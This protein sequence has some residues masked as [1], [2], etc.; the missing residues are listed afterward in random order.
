MP[1][2]LREILLHCAPNITPGLSS[3]ML[4]TIVNREPARKLSP[5]NR[6]EMTM[7][8]AALQHHSV[9]AME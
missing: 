3:S 4:I 9:R 8:L 2:R 6:I 1:K 5:V 7:S